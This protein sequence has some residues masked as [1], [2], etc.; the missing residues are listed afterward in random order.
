VQTFHYKPTSSIQIE[1]ESRLDSSD[2]G[3][4]RQSSAPA[5]SASPRSPTRAAAP[6]D[7]LLRG[8]STVHKL[9]HDQALRTV[10]WSAT[11][12]LADRSP[13]ARSVD[14]PRPSPP[15]QC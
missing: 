4:R 11:A 9:R 10:R 1:T 2:S 13:A 3:G 7:Q 8:L 12:P 14:S 15:A 6:P 5:R